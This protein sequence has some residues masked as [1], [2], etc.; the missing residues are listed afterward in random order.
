LLIYPAVWSRWRF[1][2]YLF[3][4]LPRS[5]S[6]WRFQRYLLVDLPRSW[7]RWRF[8]RYLLVDRP[9]VVHAGVSSVTFW[10]VTPQLFT[11]A[12]PALPF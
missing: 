6:R 10:W 5:W 12:F 8:Q 2:R 4:D 9:P 1:L 7:S 11:L 3:V